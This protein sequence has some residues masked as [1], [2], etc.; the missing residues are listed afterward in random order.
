MERPGAGRRRGRPDQLGSPLSLPW[1]P[2]AHAQLVEPARAP[3]LTQQRDHRVTLSGAYRVVLPIPSSDP[4]TPAFSSPMAPIGRQRPR[5]LGYPRGPAG[6]PLGRTS[7][8][9][10]IRPYVMP[11]VRLTQLASNPRMAA[12]II[13]GVSFVGMSAFRD[14]PG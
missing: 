8:P 4:A 9:R 10:R 12:V 6:Q 14:H 11:S 2:A 5:A 13:S 3:V 7:T 1:S